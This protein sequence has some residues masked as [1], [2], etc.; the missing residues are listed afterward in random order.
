MRKEG[1]VLSDTDELFHAQSIV[2]TGVLTMFFD[3]KPSGIEKPSSSVSGIL[4]LSLSEA[5]CHGR[6]FSLSSPCKAFPRL[7]HLPSHLLLG[8]TGQ[9]G[10]DTLRCL[11]IGLRGSLSLSAH[12]LLQK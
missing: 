6:P 9:L 1:C 2:E 8:G 10:G 4:R 5:Q 7:A 3:S 12:V 11:L